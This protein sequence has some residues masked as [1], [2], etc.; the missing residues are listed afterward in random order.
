MASSSSNGA[1]APHLA[2][3]FSTALTQNLAVEQGRGVGITNSAN[4]RGYPGPWA[5]FW[6]IRQRPGDHRTL[7]LIEVPLDD[8]D[9]RL[10]LS[11]FPHL[12]TRF[13]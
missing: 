13:G 5:P 6:H 1:L 9:H 12:S 7:T 4:W 8:I 3:P 11:A 2:A 10:S